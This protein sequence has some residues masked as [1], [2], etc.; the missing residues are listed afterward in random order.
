MCRSQKKSF[1]LPRFV[2]CLKPRSV[3]RKCVSPA[4]QHVAKRVLQLRPRFS[5]ALSYLAYEIHFDTLMHVP[6]VA[7]EVDG[8]CLTFGKGTESRP[9]YPSYFCGC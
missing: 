6:R 3:D 2:V 7:T 8:R 4:I 1:I 9:C 5:P